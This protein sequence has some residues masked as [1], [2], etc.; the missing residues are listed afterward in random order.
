MSVS[1]MQPAIK[2]SSI[3]WRTN[4]ACLRLYLLFGSEEGG[5]GGGMCVMAENNRTL[6]CTKR[7][8]MGATA[9][10]RIVRF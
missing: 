10:P 6:V 1:L 7:T 9:L 3:D 4:V 8:R 5:G 2:S